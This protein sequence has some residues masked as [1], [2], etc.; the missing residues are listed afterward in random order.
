[1]DYVFD[2]DGTICF[3]GKPL[4]HSM[5]AELDRLIEEGH[6]ITFASA[7]PIRDLLPILP[8]KYRSFPMIGGNGTFVYKDGKAVKIHSFTPEVAWLIKELLQRFE[9][10]YL[11]DGRWDYSFQC[12]YEHPIRLNLDPGRN[13]RNLALADLDV[14]VKAVFLGGKDMPALYDELMKLPVQVYKHGKENIFDISPG[15]V[16][17]WSGLQELGF[18][19]SQFVAFGNDANDMTLLQMASRSI[20]VGDHDDLRRIATDHVPAE[21][22]AAIAAIR[23]IRLGGGADGRAG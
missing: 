16:D 14:L 4:S 19:P 18:Q 22:E 1:M 17:K 5:V 21:E 11:V 20:C 13:A 12:S 15:H 10:D 23:Q 7:R 3:R 9:A 6:S 8:A 2:L